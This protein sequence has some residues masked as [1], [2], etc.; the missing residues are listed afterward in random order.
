MNMSGHLLESGASVVTGDSRFRPVYTINY[1]IHMYNKTI[2]YKIC[3]VY[4]KFFR[5]ESNCG[6]MIFDQ[7]VDL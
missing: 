7:Q 1:T 3:P 6:Y 2:L 5:R 4:T